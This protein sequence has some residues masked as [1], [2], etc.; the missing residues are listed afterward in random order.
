MKNIPMK[1][2]TRNSEREKLFDRTGFWFGIFNHQKYGMY[3]I[4]WHDYFELE[5]IVKGLVKYTYN[6]TSST[7][8]PGSSFLLN[9]YDN[10]SLEILEET[11]MINIRFKD[12]FLS[13]EIKEI[14]SKYNNNLHCIFDK[15]ELDYIYSLAKKAESELDFNDIFSNTI[16][17][18]II[19]EI[20]IMLIRKRNIDI[21]SKM[22]NIIQKTIAFI[23]H[24][25]KEDI[26]L[27]YIASEFG[28]SQNHLGMIF[29]KTI[30]LSFNEYLNN[31]RLKNACNLLIST[32]KSIDEIAKESGYNSTE[33]FIYVFKKYML[34]TP[35]KYRKSQ[36]NIILE[37]IP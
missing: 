12:S 18:N 34:T 11:E 21:E 23:L 24:K 30:G 37:N 19:S 13:E 15:K 29:K 14:I 6:G 9:Y 27:S 16:I 17:K 32:D 31:I 1:E 20:I 22:S 25:Y 8:V 36:K 4:H 35:A 26:S 10:H 3:P 7:A 2:I 33:Y 28:V 5:I